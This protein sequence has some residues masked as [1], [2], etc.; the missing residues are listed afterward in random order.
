MATVLP[1]W[2]APALKMPNAHLPISP[3]AIPDKGLSAIG[4]VIASLPSGPFFGPIPK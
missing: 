1:I 2:A 3:A 4:S